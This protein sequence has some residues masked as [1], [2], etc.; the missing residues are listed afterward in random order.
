MAEGKKSFILYVDQHVI[1]NKLTNDQKAELIDII[2]LYVKDENPIVSDPIVGMAFTMIQLQ[3]KRDLE[4]WDRTLISKSNAGKASAKARELK[5]QQA[6]THSTPVECVEHTQHIP[7][8]NVNDNVNDNVIVTDTD[9]VNEIKTNRDRSENKFSSFALN[10]M[11]LT[12][13]L[14]EIKKEDA[15]PP[16]SK[17]ELSWIDWIEYKW[18]QF[19]FKYKANKFEEIA[20]TGLW[21]LSGENENVAIQI[22][23][24]SIANGWKGFQ[25]I[26]DKPKG[27]VKDGFTQAIEMIEEMEENNIP[28][29]RTGPVEF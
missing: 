16:K 29:V 23:N 24:Q 7:T 3:L 8:V 14:E 6:S 15:P 2:F 10:K 18:L 25:L 19:K 1:F 20:K 11:G 13:D 28:F 4:K 26:K 12:E 5:R 22:I 21:N 27:K 17:L 9:T